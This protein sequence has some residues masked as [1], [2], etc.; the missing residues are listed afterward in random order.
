MEA[1][2][3]GRERVKQAH[4]YITPAASQVW[5]MAE[6]KRAQSIADAHRK[7]ITQLVQFG[8]SCGLMMR[9]G[10]PAAGRQRGGGQGGRGGWKL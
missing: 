3:Q 4:P 8:V 6:G 9:A 1:R 5:D 2:V 10:L 7:P